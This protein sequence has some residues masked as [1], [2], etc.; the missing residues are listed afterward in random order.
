MKLMA[1]CFLAKELKMQVCLLGS[2]VFHP[3]LNGQ[4]TVVGGGEGLRYK[5]KEP[6]SLNHYMEECVT[7][8]NPCIDDSSMS[9]D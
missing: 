9:L 3:L 2:T 6:E 1:G 8:R 5:R 4:V 7:P